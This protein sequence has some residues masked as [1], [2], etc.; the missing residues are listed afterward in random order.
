MKTRRLISIL[1]ASLLTAVAP[2]VAQEIIKTNSFTLAADETLPNETWVVA[3]DM[4][5]SGTVEADLFVLQPSTTDMLQGSGEG[6]TQSVFIVE[7]VIEEDIWGMARAIEINGEVKKS[8][9]LHGRESI[10]LNGEIRKF[11]EGESS[12]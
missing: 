11:E 7:G 12:G 5:L 9:R 2:S 4:L 1:C 10:T 6:V 8:A 3:G